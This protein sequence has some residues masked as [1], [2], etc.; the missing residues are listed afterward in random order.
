MWLT[1]VSLLRLDLSSGTQL[2]SHR[3]MDRLDVSFCSPVSFVI[4]TLPQT[5]TNQQVSTWPHTSPVLI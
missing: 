2:V 5:E 1:E 4:T 3:N